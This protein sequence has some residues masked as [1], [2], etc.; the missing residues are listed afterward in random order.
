MTKL[1]RLS[2]SVESINSGVQPLIEICGACRVLIEHHRGIAQYGNTEI[3][4]KVKNGSVLVCG[5]QLTVLLMTKEKLVIGGEIEGVRI[6]K[7]G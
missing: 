3:R 7:G 5:N 1:S 6:C 4:V 2:E